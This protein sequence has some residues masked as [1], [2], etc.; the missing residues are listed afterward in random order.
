MI[1]S[2]SSTKKPPDGSSRTLKFAHAGGIA[3]VSLLDV[4]ETMALKYIKP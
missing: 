3:T 2:S 1:P 4:P